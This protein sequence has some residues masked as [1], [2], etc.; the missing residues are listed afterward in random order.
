M[1]ERTG[2]TAAERRLLGRE[3]SAAYLGITTKSI[4]RLV[5]KGILMP[6]RLPGFRRVLFDKKDIDDMIVSNK[7]ARD[8]VLE[9]E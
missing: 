9:G 2:A 4:E 6:I 8:S 7:A 3:E 1:G 5:E